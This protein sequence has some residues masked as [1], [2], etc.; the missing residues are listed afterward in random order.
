MRLI[1][2]VSRHNFDFRV[3]NGNVDIT[4][5]PCSI[6]T[7]PYCRPRIGLASPINGRTMLITPMQSAFQNSFSFF[8]F[9]C[10][11]FFHNFLFRENPWCIFPREKH[12]NFSQTR[13]HSIIVYS[14]FVVIM[15]IIPY[16]SHVQ[17]P[18][19]HKCAN[20]VPHFRTAPPKSTAY[21]YRIQTHHSDHRQDREMGTVDVADIRSQFLQVLRSR[22]SSDGD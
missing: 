10:S 16:I 13:P 7:H 17:V 8:F 22:R 14:A 3:K 11:F 2:D 20:P 5:I 12:N 1:I 6:Q 18:T 21:K 4:P 15:T 19:T 9:F